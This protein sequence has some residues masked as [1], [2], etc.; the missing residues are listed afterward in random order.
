MENQL[1]TLWKRVFSTLEYP[2]HFK[3]TLPILRS[4]N[5]RLNDIYLMIYIDS[6]FSEMIKQLKEFGLIEHW[7]NTE[8][9][10]VAKIR[11]N[12]DS[13]AE[14]KGLTLS[15]LQA[16]IYANPLKQWLF[17]MYRPLSTFFFCWTLLQ[18]WRS[19]LKYSLRKWMKNWKE[20]SLPSLHLKIAETS[21][22]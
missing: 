2:L 19:G 16:L 10:K 13:E 3:R 14:F 1:C 4:N 11:T 8:M 15:N 17:C 22:I 7:K 6:R 9:D 12:D 18:W 20:K 21:N 5:K